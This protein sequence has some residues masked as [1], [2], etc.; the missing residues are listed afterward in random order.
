MKFAVALFALTLLA[1]TATPTFAQTSDSSEIANVPIEGK[2]NINALG[3]ADGA[4]RVKPKFTDEQKEKFYEMKNKMLSEVGPKKVALAEEQR[5]LKDLLTQDSLD[6]K[7]ILGAQDKINS[8]RT[9]LANVH[10]AYRMDIQAQLTPEQRKA[11]RY[12]GLKS[13]KNHGKR[14]HSGKLNRRAPRATGQE[15]TTTGAAPD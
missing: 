11:I 9:A 15:S 2:A 7:A 5:L 1:Q 8:L 14:R 10:L 12:H 6:R 3:G 4:A 13:G